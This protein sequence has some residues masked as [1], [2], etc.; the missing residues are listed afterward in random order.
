MKAIQLL[1]TRTLLDDDAFYETVVWRV[2]VPVP[3][4]RHLYKHRFAYVVK[5]E[6]VLRYDNERGKGDHRHTFDREEPFAF[7]TL[8]ALFAAFLTDIE[9]FRS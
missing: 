7:T 6:C 1:N 4:S 8:E 9:R 2:P 3:G 5:G